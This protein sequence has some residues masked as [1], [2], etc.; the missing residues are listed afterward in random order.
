V[1]ITRMLKKVI[2]YTRL[3]RARRTRHFPSKAAGRSKRRRRYPLGY[4]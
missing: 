1:R 4:V 3:S 2:H